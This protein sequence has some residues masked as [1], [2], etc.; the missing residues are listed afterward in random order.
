MTST[1][2]QGFYHS[3][4]SCIETVKLLK[5]HLPITIKNK[6][7]I[8]YFDVLDETGN[9]SNDWRGGREVF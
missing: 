7:V 6:N 8:L 2:A 1:L 3:Y 9:L 4:E 5:F